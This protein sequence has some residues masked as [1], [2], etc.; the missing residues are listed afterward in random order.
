MSSATMDALRNRSAHW[1]APAADLELS[2]IDLEAAGPF[3]SV[4]LDLREHFIFKIWADVTDVGAT[5]GDFGLAV[6]LFER[7]GVTEI[8]EVPLYTL[9]SANGSNQ[10]SILFGAGAD[11]DLQGTATI[12]TTL[13]GLKII[14]LAKIRVNINVQADGAS[15]LSVRMQMGD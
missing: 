10:V 7:D 9:Q 11:A 4:L 14:Q 2:G 5:T 3:D 6:V 15:T 1:E 12:G 8:E 13:A